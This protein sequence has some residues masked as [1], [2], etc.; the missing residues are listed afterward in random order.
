MSSKRLIAFA[1][2]SVLGLSV[3]ACGSDK[4]ASTT[5]T[6]TAATTP[7]TTPA[8]A[9]TTPAT[10]ATTPATAATT[11]ATAA[12]TPTTP[13]TGATA[14]TTA[15]S[16]G[17]SSGLTGLAL[18]QGRV[19]EFSKTLT[20]LGLTEKVKAPKG[21]KVAYVQCS[22]PVCES[23]KKGIAEAVDAIGGTLQIF[24]TQDTA[25]TVQ[26][27]FEAAVQSNPDMVLTSGNPRAWFETSLAKL[28]AKKIPVVAWSM[29]E[30]YQAPGLAANLITGDDYYFNGVL[31]ADYVAAKTK[32]KAN[33]LF[34]NIPQ[35]PVL[36]LESEGFK[37]EMASV[38][39][40]C[41]VTSLDFTVDQLIAGNHISAAVSEFQKDP[42]I[43]YLV[44]GF[45]D[46]LLGMPDAL[47]GIHVT[48][49]AISQAGTPANYQLI[50]DGSLQVADVGLPTGLLGW[51][52][53]DAG[54]RAI[55]G[56]SPGKFASRQLTTIPGHP[57]INI[58]GVP[59]GI[60]QKGD[61]A[62]PTVA[63]AAI[64]GYQE[65]FKALWIPG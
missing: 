16:T 51:R 33:A 11:P 52:A 4:T 25:D 55:A 57:D 6:P 58:A 28:N 54:L 30:P 3:A 18:A 17:G 60:R 61:I 15:G 65:L 27:A 22:V 29:P 8:A 42:A 24:T 35:F 14:G 63:W 48:V 37:A 34:L 9:A 41:K 1:A 21:L 19:D 23:I 7:A 2:V 45:G 32:G 56:Q 64:K 44:T 43:N 13:A 5:T 46:M 49:P 47:K 31:M 53:I 59:L 10:A 50:A 12:T 26:A 40:G 62:D 39:P 20:D 36:G 38:C